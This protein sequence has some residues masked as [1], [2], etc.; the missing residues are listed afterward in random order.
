MIHPIMVQ[1]QILKEY[2]ETQECS[3]VSVIV[4][5]RNHSFYI[6]IHKNLD[7]LEESLCIN[8]NTTSD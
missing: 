8:M 5:F 3:F 6:G 1:L 2:T 7:N 4:F